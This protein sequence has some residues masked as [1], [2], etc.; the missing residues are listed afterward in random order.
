MREHR[1]IIRSGRTSLASRIDDQSRPLVLGMREGDEADPPDACISGQ[2]GRETCLDRVVFLQ[3]FYKIR[4]FKHTWMTGE[5]GP[6][7]SRMQSQSR[8][9]P[10]AGPM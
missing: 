5:E 10:N 1:N 4:E 9:L 3:Q 7:M 2:A 8:Q 6:T